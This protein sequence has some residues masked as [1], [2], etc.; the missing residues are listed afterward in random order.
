[1]SPL[2]KLIGRR[3]VDFSYESDSAGALFEGEIKLA[4][5][6]AMIAYKNHKKGR[7]SVKNAV[8][9]SARSSSDSVDIEFDNGV[10]W[11]IDLSDG[12]Y[13]GPESLEL[14]IPGES[15]VVWRQG[16]T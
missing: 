13:A 15:I 11:R 4:I 16:D 5:F 2:E 1:M 6:N 3:V 12:A 7:F 9:S 14:I 8:V 10:M